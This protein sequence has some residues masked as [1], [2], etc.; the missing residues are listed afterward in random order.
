MNT[1]PG[2]GASGNLSCDRTRAIDD[3]DRRMRINTMAVNIGFTG[4]S[5]SCQGDDK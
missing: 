4:V 1:A 5:S 2:L 3:F